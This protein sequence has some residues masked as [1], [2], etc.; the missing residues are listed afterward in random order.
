MATIR[1]QNLAKELKVDVLQLMQH[2][3]DNLGMQVTYLSTLDE[4]T[5]SSDP[6]RS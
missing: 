3:K 6:R 5:A 2:L 4:G 1:V